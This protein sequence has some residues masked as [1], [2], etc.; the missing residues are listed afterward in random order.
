MAARPDWP[1]KRGCDDCCRSLA[2]PMRISRAEWERI[3]HVLG[4]NRARVEAHIDN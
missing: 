2:S 4:N 1:C 3:E